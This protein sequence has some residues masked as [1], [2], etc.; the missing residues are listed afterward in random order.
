MGSNPWTYIG[1]AVLAAAVCIIGLSA[2]I[3]L[4]MS[5]FSNRTVNKTVEDHLRQIEK[6]LPGRNCGECGCENCRMYAEAA[7]NRDLAFDKCPYGNE[8]L[9]EA[10]EACVERFWKIANDRAPVDK[11]QFWQRKDDVGK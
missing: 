2:I 10:L 11:R 9:P 8:G 1:I 6:L 3:T 7:L 4:I 5:L